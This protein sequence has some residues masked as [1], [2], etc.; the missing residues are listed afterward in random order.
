MHDSLV[1]AVVADNGEEVAGVQSDHTSNA[2]FCSAESE[3]ASVSY[4]H[5]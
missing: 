5:N 1:E 3:V 4:N 2:S